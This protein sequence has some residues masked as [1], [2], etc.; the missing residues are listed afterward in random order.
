MITLD[1]LCL[2]QRLNL[3]HVTQ[4]VKPQIP[5]ISDHHED[6][7]LVIFSDKS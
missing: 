3:Q 6:I 1:P 5:V 4:H 7:N 2:H